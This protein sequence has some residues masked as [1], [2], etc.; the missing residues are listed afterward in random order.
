TKAT[1]IEVV[2]I[3]TTRAWSRSGSFGTF[4]SRRWRSGPG[5][6]GAPVLAILVVEFSILRVGKYIVR[7]LQLLEL[8]LGSFVTRIQIGVKLTRQFAISLLD[9]VVGGTALNAEH[10]VI[11]FDIRRHRST[12]AQNLACGMPRICH[13]IARLCGDLRSKTMRTA[14]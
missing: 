4:P 9:L 11:V 10:R 5:F 6:N 1:K 2:E 12:A 7:L 3:E 13:G 8:I 14:T